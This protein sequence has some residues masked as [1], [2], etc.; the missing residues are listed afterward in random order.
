MCTSPQENIGVLCSGGAAAA[1]TSSVDQGDKVS[2]EEGKCDNIGSVKEFSG[3]EAM[4]L[5]VDTLSPIFGS[6]NLGDLYNNS[7]SQTQ[8]ENYRPYACLTY[9]PFVI[10]TCPLHRG[11]GTCILNPACVWSESSNSCSAK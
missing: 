2:K 3:L 6:L 4:C 1:C 9:F 8:Y 10:N 7:D 5:E 11:V